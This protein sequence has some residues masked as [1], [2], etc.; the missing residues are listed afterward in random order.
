MKKLVSLILIVT[1]FTIGG[2][3]F[4]DEYTP[5]VPNIIITDFKS[6]PEVEA[7]K[8]LDLSLTL[9]N[10]SLYSAKKITITPNLAELPI[11]WNQPTD[12]SSLF[13]LSAKKQTK[14]TF[15]FNISDD[16]RIGTY[17]IKFD[18]EYFNSRDERYS[19]SQTVYFK[20]TSEK[21]KPILVVDSITTDA[22]PI[23]AGSQLVL[24]FNVTNIGD[25]TAKDVKLVLTG[26]TKDSFM[27]VDSSDTRYIATLDG[28]ASSKQF[29]TLLVSKNIPKG[30][31]PINVSLTYKDTL[32]NDYTVEKVIYLN[33]IQSEKDGAS[34]EGGAPKVMIQSYYTSP[35]SIRAGDNI[36]FNFTFIN[37]NIAK[38][39]NNI[40]ITID[41]PE[42]ALMIAKGS[43]T[44][45][46]ENLGPKGTVEKNISLN[47]KQDL[48]SKSYPININFDYEDS[49]GEHYTSEEVISLPVIEYSKLVI[50]NVYAPEAYFGSPLN[51]SFD[52]INMGK[53][54]V[55]NLTA[56]VS[57]DYVSKQDV[58]YIG[59]LEAGNSDY[60]DI[61]IYPS[62]AGDLNGELILSFED[63]SGK[64][65]EVKKSFQGFA[66]DPSTEVPGGEVVDPIPTPVEEEK[67]MSGWAIGGIGFGSFLISFIVTKIIAGKIIRKKLEDEI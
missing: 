34:G 44:F 8:T 36:D 10:D 60:Y 47:V 56:S 57:G 18:L 13:A 16:A 5:K 25:I 65:I 23:I 37:T 26:L 24:S 19:R 55:S 32:N 43:N 38:S 54:K 2:A 27:A 21:S 58:N 15:N 45:Y 6:M 3:V 42:G 31:N 1:F 12:Y 4:A 46:I 35:S 63:S 50:N 29:F 61:E 53:A 40:K 22:D 39:I 14:V 41:S 20:V 28:K 11:K 67:P 51:L 48:T 64:V 33:N 66:M 9:E 62:K 59:N 49:S 30:T 7:G 17:G 52:Y